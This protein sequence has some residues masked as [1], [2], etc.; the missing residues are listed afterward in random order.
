MYKYFSLFI[1]LIVA[2]LYLSPLYSIVLTPDAQRNMEASNRIYSGN[3]YNIPSDEYNRLLKHSHF[4]KHGFNRYPYSYYY[5]TYSYSY[6][7]YINPYA[8]YAYDPWFN[9]PPP[10][11]YYEAFPDDARAD[12]LYRYLQS[13]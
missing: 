13:R 9:S 3:I 2:T 1:I 6:P 10:P 7:T 12:A 4:K 5:P 8:S 11:T